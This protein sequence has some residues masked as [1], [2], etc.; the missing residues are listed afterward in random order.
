MGKELTHWDF[1]KVKQDSFD[2]WNQM[3]G[4]IKVEGGTKNEQVRFYSD[5]WHSLLG[6]RTISDAGWKIHGSDRRV[7]ASKDSIKGQTWEN[8]F[9]TIISMHYGEP[10][11]RLTL[12]GEWL[13]LKFM[14]D[15][16][17]HL[18]TCIMMAA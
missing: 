15:S 18:S 1:N 4:R 3:L 11:G 2:E 8:P 13:I 6:R 5:L 9:R 16:A 17:I 12:F 14:T 7:S 10:S